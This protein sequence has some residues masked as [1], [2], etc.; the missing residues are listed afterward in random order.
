MSRVFT[1]GRPF[2][3]PLV[4]GEKLRRPALAATLA[5]LRANGPE[6]FYRGPIAQGI[7]KAVREAGGVM[8]LEDLARY[9]PT[10]RTPLSTVYRGFRVFSM[11]PPSSGGILVTQALGILAQRWPEPPRGAD[12]Y[13]SAYLHV[14]S[15]ALKHGF[16]DRARHLG[17]PDFVQVPTE[18]LADPAY[19]REL[20][21]RIKIDGVLP[22]ERYG[23][24]PVT[25]TAEIKG[26]GTAHLS[27]IDGE[28]NAVAL[29][30]TVNL[31]FGAHVVAGET[32]IVLNNEIDDFSV[33][34]DMPNAFGLIG[35]DKNI[36]G[37]N[38]RPLSSMTPTLVLEGDGVKMAVGGAGGP[39]IISAT[40]QVLLHVLDGKMNAQEASVAPRVH[41]QWSPELL[42]VEPEVP[43]DVVQALEK[44][45]HKIR[46]TD[47]LARVNVI[48]RGPDGVEAAA[49][50]RGRG[51][52]AGH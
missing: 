4:P 3:I 5:R 29:T 23:M 40:L 50:F 21:A 33:A 45:G 31:G 41:H 6:A 28:G 14:L 9:A 24:P 11:P 38:K 52:P 25:P 44:R 26:G 15:E 16:A 20:A 49:E 7:V 32:G 48:V 46:T 12:R 39:R 35:K 42:L 51:V 43:R 8:T 47:S 10:E 37:P 22:A 19:H 13:S 1:L 27:V 18:K 34:P 2:A 17:D 36:V 30:T